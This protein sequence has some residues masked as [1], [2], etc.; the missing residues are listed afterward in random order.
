MKSVRLVAAVLAFSL[1]GCASLTGSPLDP[2]NMVHVRLQDKP[3][4]GAREQKYPVT[5]RVAPYTDGRSGVDPRQIGISTTRILGLTGKQIML[6]REVANLVGE[7][8]Q[9]QLGDTGLQV[10][11]SDAK[12]AQFQLTGSIK[13]LSV[14]FRER[15]YLNIVIESTLTEVASGRVVWSGVVAEKNDRYAGSS[16]NGK[17]D[18]ADFLR[19]GLQVISTKTSES[20]LSVLMS[21]SPDLFGLDAAVKPVPGV[22]VNS[23]A[24]PGASLPPPAAAAAAKG[25]LLLDSTPPRARVYVDDV[26]FG[27]TPLRIELAPGIYPVRLELEGYQSVAEKVSVRSED[28]TELEMK[29][30]K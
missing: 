15:D 12:N 28:H 30:R 19:R 25:T 21:T 24:I 20:L 14:D 4:P 9:K 13:I 11:A 7:V 1:S 16:G 3:S 18:V 17:Q 6:D 2:S 29:L 10:L 5:V 23:T 26:Y 27:L 8:M 22:T